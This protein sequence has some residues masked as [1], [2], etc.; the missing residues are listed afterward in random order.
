[1][2]LMTSDGPLTLARDVRL[3]TF[4]GSHR[5]IT[6]AIVEPMWSGVRV[7]I[8]A[9]GLEAAM[10]ADGEALDTHVELRNAFAAATARTSDGVIVEAWLTRQIASGDVGVYT[11]ADGDLPTTG[12]LV[13]QVLL[14]SRADRLRT[15]TVEL[16][17]AHAARELD[18]DDPVNLVVVDLLW[19]DGQWLLDVPLL[20]RKRI[21][22]SVVPAG[23][24]IRPGIHVKP[25]IDG[26]VGS[27]RAQGFTGL[28][29]RAANSR[30]RP[31]EAATDWATAP[32]PRR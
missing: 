4:G 23:V 18:G 19:L 29:F 8:G 22:E 21:L 13:S 26:W 6:D 24:L 14:G 3:P 10:F 5:S 17:A 27:W 31:G 30:Y 1:M 15:K 9:H 25:P 11:G 28:T 32:M 12:S 20:E 16:E 7:V 2:P